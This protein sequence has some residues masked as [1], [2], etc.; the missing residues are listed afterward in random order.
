MRIRLL[1]PFI[2]IAGCG[3]PGTGSTTVG[4]ESVTNRSYDA[5]AY[6]LKA[7]FDWT[8]KT[9]TGSEQVTIR[10]LHARSQAYE[11]EIMR[12]PYTLW[13]AGVRY[14]F[15]TDDP[16]VLGWRQAADRSPAR[17]ASDSLTVWPH[18]FEPYWRRDWS[19]WATAWAQLDLEIDSL[20]RTPA[21]GP[22]R[23][24]EL[25]ACGRQG[26]ATFTLGRSLLPWRRRA[27]RECLLE[28]TSS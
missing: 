12:S 28:S 14:A 10:G 7:K 24:L 16:V 25:V 20:L 15:H 26:A 21:A 8:T 6:D 4:I 23:S 11:E 17:T 1:L 13:K 5:I 19:A 2:L 22:R 27:L 18:L 3:Q 9:L